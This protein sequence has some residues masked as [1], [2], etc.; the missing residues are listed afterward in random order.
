MLT[1]SLVCF[2]DFLANDP[3]CIVDDGRRVELH[4]LDCI[5]ANH[6]DL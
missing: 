1:I 4:R 6:A 3:A 2:G 5:A